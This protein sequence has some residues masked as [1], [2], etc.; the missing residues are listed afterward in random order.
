M[1]LTKPLALAT[2]F[3]ANVPLPVLAADSL[4]SWNSTAPKQ[5]IVTFVEKVTNKGSPDSV[6]VAKRIAVFDNDSTLWPE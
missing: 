2:L 6:P 3:V 1:K 5:T 4:T